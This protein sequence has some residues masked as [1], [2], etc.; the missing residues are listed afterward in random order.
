VVPGILT[1]FVNHV[2]KLKFLAKIMSYAKVDCSHLNP[3]VK[4]LT[5]CNFSK[6]G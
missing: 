6:H 3:D 5:K 4:R 2:L 1:F